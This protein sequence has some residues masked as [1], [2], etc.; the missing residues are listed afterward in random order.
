MNAPVSIARMNPSQRR[1]TEPGASIWVTASAGTGKTRVLANRIARL[2][3]GG[4]KPHRILALTYTNA[5][6]A[7]MAQRV[8]QTLARWAVCGE[9]ELSAIL[10]DLT[11]EGPSAAQMAQARRCFAEVLDSP[12]GLR[13][14][15]IHGFCQSL[16]RR[17][18]IEAGVA[19]HF[20]LIDDRT[21]AEMLTQ[22][23]SSVL[24]RA[25]DN[26]E[27]YGADA[28]EALADYA[29]DSRALELVEKIL[30]EGTR[31]ED[32][33]DG[34]SDL[35][36]AY[37]ALLGASPHDTEQAI[38]DAAGQDEAFD[39]G[40]LRR[41]A[42]V[43]V[44]GSANYRNR[45]L[46]ILNWLSARPANRAAG[47]RAYA[48]RFNVTLASL[49]T[50]A[51]E[52]E[53]S[54]I[55]EVLA[56]EKE[57]TEAVIGR[58]NPVALAR[59]STG[60][61]LFAK[62]VA[63]EYERQKALSG[64]LDYGD[65]I[66]K[67]THLLTDA[68]ARAWVL[69]KLDG[70]LDHILVDEAQDNSR[71]QW[72]IFSTLA[73]EMVAG[74]G[75]EGQSRSLFVVGD[76]K[77]SIYRFQGAA[78][79]AFSETRGWIEHQL[80]EA[81]PERQLQ[82][83]DLT[84]SYRCAPP[85]LSLVDEVL[86]N[87]L[88]PPGAFL[89]E[90]AAIGH[91]AYDPDGKPGLVELW[92]LIDKPAKQPRTPWPLPDNYEAAEKAE[93]LLAAG[94]AGKI[95]DL[96]ADPVAPVAPG[97]ILVLLRKR[98]VFAQALI[99]ELKNRNVPVE[100]AD[101][102]E[103]SE[104]LAVKDLL[105]LGDFLLQ[106]DDDLSLATVLRGPL[107]GLSDDELFDLAHDR[108]GAGLWQQLA[109][110]APDSARLTAVKDYLSELLAEVDFSGPHA[111]LEA[112]LSTP[113]PADAVSGRRALI[114]RL[115]RPVNDPVDELLSQALA[116]EHLHAPSIQ[117]FLTWLR[118]TEQPLKRDA[119]DAGAGVRVMTIHGAKGLEANTVI[120]ADIYSRPPRGDGLFWVAKAGS[121]PAM[122]V[123]RPAK[124]LSCEAVDRE[125]SRE[126]EADNA[127]VMRLLYVALTRAERR[128][129]ICGTGKLTDGK[130]KRRWVD[131]CHEAMEELEPRSSWKFVSEAVPEW[132]GEAVTYKLRDHL[133]EHKQILGPA[134]AETAL[135]DWL[136]APAPK[137]VAR[138]L[139]RPSR[140][141]VEGAEPATVSPLAADGQERFRRGLLIH[142]LL[143]RLPSVEP[144]RRE[145]AGRAYL[146][147]PAHGLDAAQVEDYL[148]E[149]LSVIGDPEFGAI[150]S[151]EALVEAPIV[152]QVGETVING[153]I[154]RMVVGES[155]ILIVDFK[156]NRPPPPS[157]EQ[158]AP[159]YLRQ[160]AGYRAVL[161]RI[162]PGRLIKCAL[163]W[164]VEARL[165][166]LPDA[167][168][169]KLP[170]DSG[171]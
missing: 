159:I 115:G 121:G 170:N 101:R 133:F 158:T 24:S 99:R 8:H 26:P 63:G 165:M 16:L 128:L 70:G 2:L 105:A 122:P 88:M 15:T 5:A 151:A 53:W 117:G 143:E 161:S 57:R 46:A 127:E 47:F 114:A 102:L 45:G 54:E 123:W 152:G 55:R 84:L 18:P 162:Y 30:L 71:A 25:G 3:L 118:S 14:H 131:F 110:A 124:E 92:P 59:V 104:D 171:S 80:A 145:E 91:Q 138:R 96:V 13:A 157:V 28:V 95:A 147:G 66:D 144:E 19:P 86:R 112:I 33:P 69:Y 109:G 97:D 140:W 73:E 75:G 156:T 65:L 154:D 139:I 79:D 83:I 116:Y 48:A 107:I 41:A 58:A 129:Y 64:Y 87:P 17:F 137:A 23:R 125:E 98:G 37:C 50:K 136:Y 89:P 106:R 169:A 7:E 39:G 153:Q 160:M 111:F 34:R 148:R 35:H 60:L 142:T 76:P 4:C 120:L 9:S 103:L 11:G 119:S 12:I 44:E 100:G 168:L 43:L 164:T 21:K 108:G 167:L 85:I 38:F 72:T 132:E 130:R 126:T 29:D 20:S 67:A 163:L 149:A 74:S 81:P 82:S 52:K 40:A 68:D 93:F 51:M 27:G 90:A 1:A 36:S 166:V 56:T 94:V 32:V 77:Q 134:D 135:P 62:A 31:L 42:G 10:S 155:E 150:F 22:A 49:A 141:D 6:A 113:C 146:S 78:P 61:V